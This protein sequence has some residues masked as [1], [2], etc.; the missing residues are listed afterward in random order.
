MG[1]LPQSGSGGCLL[2]NSPTPPSLLDLD[3]IDKGNNGKQLQRMCSLNR[4]NHFYCNK[5]APHVSIPTVLLSS[6]LVY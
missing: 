4:R 6:T 1:A 5:A 2:A 3:D